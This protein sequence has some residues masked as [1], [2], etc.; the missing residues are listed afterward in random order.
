[1]IPFEDPTT[2]SLLYHINSEPWLNTIAYQES[3]YE[4]EYKRISAPGSALALPSP[5]ESPLQRLIY[6]RYSCRR[7][8]KREL[9]MATL[10]TLLF[11]AYG[12]TRKMKFEDGTNYFCRS[13]P[14]AGGLYPLEV[15]ALLQRVERVAEGLYHYDV[16]NHALEPV[17]MGLA[18]AGLRSAM[19]AFPFFGDANILCLLVAVFLRAQKK[20]GPR[21][22]RFILL[23]AGHSA[24][25]ICLAA[26]ESG[27]AS[28]CIGGY[29]DAK[30]NQVMRLDPTQEG[31]VYA[32]A[33]GYA[34]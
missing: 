7:Y 27:L 12:L 22:Y 3:G 18:S 29:L 2:L 15:Y 32:V 20:Y 28:L 6:G 23:E 21:G 34:A 11:A 14:S 1:M 26:T 25:N 19:L 4:I 13:V 9:P 5:A 17:E 30:L 31:V 10:S 8:E 24:Q 16:L 33:A